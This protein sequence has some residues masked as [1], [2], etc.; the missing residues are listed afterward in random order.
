VRCHYAACVSYA[1]AQ[2]GKILAE[3]KRTGA[4]KNT[5]VILRGDH[6]WHLGEHVIWGKHILFEESLHSPLIIRYPNM[7]TKNAT[8]NTIV[9]TLDVFPILCDLTGIDTPNFT[10]GTPL[11]NLL[12]NSEKKG[13]S[14]VAYTKNYKKSTIRTSTHRMIFHENDFIELYHHTSEEKETNWL[15][16]KI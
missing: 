5:I 12:E 15:S 7:K 13:H 10:Q 11:V 9:E 6:G 4:D 2:V 8:T 3:L 14:A 1:D 16:F